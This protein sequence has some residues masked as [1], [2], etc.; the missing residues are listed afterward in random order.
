MKDEKCVLAENRN[1][2]KNY[3]LMKLKAEY[4]STHSKPGNFIMLAA[5]KTSE[6]LLKR[7]FGIFDS[8]PPFIRIY[9]EIVG[10]G[11][12]I[13]ASLK[14][15]DVVDVIGPLGNSFPHLEKKNILMVAGGRGMGGDSR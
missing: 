2:H 3:F 9:Y 14:P 4:I 10:K 7:P 6:P 12:E 15:G 13:I 11:T 8:E 5:S 1:I